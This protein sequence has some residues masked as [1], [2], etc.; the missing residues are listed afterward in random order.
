MTNDFVKKRSYFNITHYFFLVFQQVD[1]SVL[2]V[3]PVVKD[4]GDVV[5][6]EVLIVGHGYH[7]SS[8]CDISKPHC[9]SSGKFDRRFHFLYVKPR[10]I[11]YYL[12]SGTFR[13]G[14]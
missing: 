10:V 6:D 13:R 11:L 1:E 8:V 12:V 3:N 14:I 4:D 9:E 2:P 7:C 5:I